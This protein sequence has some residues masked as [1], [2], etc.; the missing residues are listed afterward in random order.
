MPAAPRHAGMRREQTGSELGFLCA[1][2][3]ESPFFHF[4]AAQTG[5]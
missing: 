2:V 1:K 5:L 4:A 3:L